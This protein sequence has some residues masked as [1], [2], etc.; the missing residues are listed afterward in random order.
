[1]K[2]ASYGTYDKLASKQFKAATTFLPSTCYNLFY[3]PIKDKEVG[4][5]EASVTFDRYP[6]D[7]PVSTR[8]N[9]CTICDKQM[10]AYIRVR[11][12]A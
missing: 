11:D 8:E 9:E 4:E 1:M 10:P 12:K 2:E 7:L 5:M 3:S 6:R